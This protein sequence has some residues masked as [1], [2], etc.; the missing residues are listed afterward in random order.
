MAYTNKH[1]IIHKGK[2]IDLLQIERQ[3]IEDLRAQIRLDLTDIQNQIDWARSDFALNDMPYDRGWMR[4]ATQAAKIKTLDIE[5]I[6]E[7]LKGMPYKKDK[8]SRDITDLIRVIRDYLDQNLSY[9]S[10]VERMEYLEDEY[11]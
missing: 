5:K 7:V 10:L 3:E 8:A 1:T 4:S 11:G 2:K 6:G 9:E